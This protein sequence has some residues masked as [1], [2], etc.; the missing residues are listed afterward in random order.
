MKNTNWFVITGAPRSGKTKAI[1]RLA[2]YGYKTCPEIARLLF[3]EYSSKGFEKEYEF[4][5]DILFYEKLKAEKNFHE[6]EIV[7]FDRC[8]I[9]SIAFAKLYNKPYIDYIEKIN[10]QYKKIFFIESLD[11]YNLDYATQETKEEAQFLGE[12]LIETYETLNYKLIFV[13]KM[14]ISDRVRYIKNEITK[15]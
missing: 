11:N 5:E 9:D 6:N 3:D 15:E 14:S 2:Y 7:F 12:L 13:P 4:V 8:P 10:F 1:E